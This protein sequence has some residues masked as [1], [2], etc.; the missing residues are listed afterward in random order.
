[1]LLDLLKQALARVLTQIEI[2]AELLHY[3]IWIVVLEHFYLLDVLAVQ[4]D[5]ED[6]DRLLDYREEG[7]QVAIYPGWWIAGGWRLLLM[8]LWG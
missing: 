5:F 8:E 2:V 6:A 1:M 7:G 3:F 4:L